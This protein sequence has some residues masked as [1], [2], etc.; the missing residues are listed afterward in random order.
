M[1]ATLSGA[2]EEV[3]GEARAAKADAGVAKGGAG[4]MPPPPIALEGVPRPRR[5]AKASSAHN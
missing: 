1:V 5:H 3:R 2:R 4:A